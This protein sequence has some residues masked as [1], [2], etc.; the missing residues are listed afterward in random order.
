MPFGRPDLTAFSLLAIVD[1]DVGM[2]DMDVETSKFEA[3]EI[4]KDNDDVV[5]AVI[6]VRGVVV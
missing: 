3:A 4:D 2:H 1:S 5:V 6:I